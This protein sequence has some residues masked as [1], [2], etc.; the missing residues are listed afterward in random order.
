MTISKT[1]A[2]HA[3]FAGKRRRFCLRLGEI[4]ELE[5]LCGAGVGLITKRLA[6]GE[7]KNADVRESIRLGL[8]GG[9][10][11]DLSPGLVDAMVERYV[12]GRP[13]LENL[14]LAQSI[15]AAL[16]DGVEE[17]ARQMPGKSEEERSD[18]RETSPPL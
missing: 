11:D 9:E 18:F 4:A 12:D 15:I 3:V 1:T 17:S 5:Q 14:H 10:N 2:H 7:F 6:R 13:V 16:M 8:V